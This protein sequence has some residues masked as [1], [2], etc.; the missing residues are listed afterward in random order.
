MRVIPATKKYQ[1]MTNPKGNK[2]KFI[3]IQK[4]QAH[5]DN[6]WRYGR[7]DEI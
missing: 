7:I 2:S 1:I 4:T 5:L 3:E 6:G